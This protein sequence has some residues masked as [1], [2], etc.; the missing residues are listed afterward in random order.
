MTNTTT[1]RLPS[2]IGSELNNTAIHPNPN[3]ISDKNTANM[4]INAT[5]LYPILLLV[6]LDT[7]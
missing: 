3:E 6:G 1:N 7:C 2:I 5:T 4:M